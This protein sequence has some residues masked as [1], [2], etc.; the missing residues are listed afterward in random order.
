[1]GQNK[2]SRLRDDNGTGAVGVIPLYHRVYTILSQQIRE[3][4]FNAETPLPGEQQIA[5]MYGVSR[6]TVRKALQRLEQEG[7]IIRQRGRGTFPIMD[8]QRPP[9]GKLADQMTIMQD[10]D[11]QVL[12]Y[13]WAGATPDIAQGL[14]IKQGDPTLRV[15]RLRMRNRI[16]LAMGCSWMAERAGRL[17]DEDSVSQTPIVE[18]LRERGLAPGVVEQRITATLADADLSTGLQVAPGSPVILMQ[19]IVYDIDSNPII[20]IRSHYR[21]DRYSYLVTLF[22]DQDGPTPRWVEIE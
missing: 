16:P 10:T 9:V 14:K 17:L 11:S 1:M 19:R 18:L 6:V 22:P 13:E 7:R 2:S 21:P 15:D 3:G 4:Q 5:S 12:L 20:F 8:R